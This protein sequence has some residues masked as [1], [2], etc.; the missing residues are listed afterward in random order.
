MSYICDVTTIDREG[1]IIYNDSRSFYC[2]SMSVC[3][4]TMHYE[5]VP[6]MP[7]FYLFIFHPPAD[8]EK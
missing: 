4:E 3:A 7:R 5:V 6:G 2:S 1:G 8:G